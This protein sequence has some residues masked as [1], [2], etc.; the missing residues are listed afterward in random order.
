[1]G[2]DFNTILQET[3]VFYMFTN[4]ETAKTVLA[5]NSKNKVSITHASLNFFIYV[6][7]NT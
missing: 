4:N 5:H 7:G 2:E 3:H 6:I 1:M